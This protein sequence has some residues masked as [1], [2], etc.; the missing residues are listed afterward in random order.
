LDLSWNDIEEINEIDEVAQLPVLEVL[1]LNG[2]PLARAV[3]YRPR[4]MSR[5]GERCNE[6]LL[7]NERCSPTEIDKA[8]VLAALRISKMG[9]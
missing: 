9:K 1:G 3:D 7:D 4:V 6:I 8:L 2:N 5:F